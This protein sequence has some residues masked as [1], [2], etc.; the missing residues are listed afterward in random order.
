MYERHHGLQSLW[1]AYI[2]MLPPTYS[3]PLYWS[4]EVF[5]SLP[6]AISQEAAM[7]VDKFM[8]N[9]SRLQGLFRHIETTV[10][11]NIVGAFTLSS[12]KWAWSSVSTRCVYMPPASFTRGISEDNCIA[13]APML[14]LLNHSP[15][16]QVII[17]FLQ[18]TIA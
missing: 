16:V 11:E 2:N 17:V 15:N 13:L 8:N 18:F 10:A 4:S 3:T 14:D 1:F 9:F 5:S 6:T 12:F 7:L